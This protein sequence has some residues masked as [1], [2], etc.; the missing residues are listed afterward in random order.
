MKNNYPKK[1]APEYFAAAACVLQH[2]RWK[3]TPKYDFDISFI[4]F[5]AKRLRIDFFSALK[6]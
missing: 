2:A 6:N 3:V 5:S 1:N 4:H